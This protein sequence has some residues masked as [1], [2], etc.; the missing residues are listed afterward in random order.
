MTIDNSLYRWVIA[1]ERLPTEKDYLNTFGIIYRNSNGFPGLK[2]ARAN[3]S[4][5]TIKASLTFYMWL[6]KIEGNAKLP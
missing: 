1:S 3:F 5:K 6:E 4:V 2:Q